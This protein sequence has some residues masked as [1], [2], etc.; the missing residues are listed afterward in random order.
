MGI[1]PPLDSEKLKR[2]GRKK[3]L[4]EHRRQ[5]GNQSWMSALEEL[6]ATPD[7]EDPILTDGSIKEEHFLFI[8]ASTFLVIL[9]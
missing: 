6:K 2:C 1:L 4:K 8:C 5:R 9:S 3:N 7:Q